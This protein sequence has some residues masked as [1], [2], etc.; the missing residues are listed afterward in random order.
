VNRTSRRLAPSSAL[1]L[2]ALAA[3]ACGSPPLPKANSITFVANSGFL[4]WAG[5]KKV[6]VDGLFDKFRGRPG[7]PTLVGDGKAP[8]DDIDLVL[9]THSD[10]DHFSASAVSRCLKS[11]PRAAFV[12][13]ADA[14]R[15]VTGF[16]GRVYPLEIAE[17]QRRHLAVNGIGIDAMPLPHA[18]VDRNGAPVN[19]GYLITIGNRK[20]F[21]TGDISPEA[22]TVAYM[23]RFNLPAG[24]ID[25]AFVPH[26][27]LS[28]QA[29]PAPVTESIQ[30]RVVFASHVQRR[31]LLDLVDP[32][33]IGPEPPNAGQIKRNFP[34]AVVPRTQLESWP[35]R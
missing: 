25:V 34:S 28:R 6:L 11:N 15:Q 1:A 35:I 8:F 14:A 20:F 18:G 3:I 24:H 22:L 7:A 23:K 19:L 4:I 27:F 5:E 30:P 12:A 13:P 10:W 2:V 16:D 9:A 26:Y 33:A 32:F 29:P 17:G 21:H 31:G